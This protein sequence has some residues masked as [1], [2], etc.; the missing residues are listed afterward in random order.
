MAMQLGNIH[1]LLEGHAEYDSQDASSAEN[2]SHL[3]KELKRQ[4]KL[5][6][7]ALD[8]AEVGAFP[9]KQHAFTDRNPSWLSS[10]CLP[11]YRLT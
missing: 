9:C 10:I 6:G 11:A 2:V 8:A 7:C 4:I 5:A 3:S 1:N